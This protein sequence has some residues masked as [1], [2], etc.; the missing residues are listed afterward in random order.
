MN[1]KSRRAKQKKAAAAGAGPQQQAMLKR[2]FEDG[3]KLYLNRKFDD[4]LG[5]FHKIVRA[6]PNIPVVWRHMALAARAMHDYPS[7]ERYINKTIELQPNSAEGYIAL[8]L[9][10]RDQ[11]KYDAAEAA[12]KKAI[13]INPDDAETYVPLSS[14]YRD[15]GEA[16]AARAPLDKALELNPDLVSAHHRRALV[17]DF[18]SKNDDVFKS[19]I[20]MDK[21]GVEQGSRE[22]AF[23]KSAIAKAYEDMGRH[24]DAFAYT[25][26]A[27]DIMRGAFGYDVANDVDYMRR[28]AEFFT[29]E[30][31]AAHAGGGVASDRPVFI[32]GMPRSGT[33]LVE[34][35]L[36]SHPRVYG[37]GELEA[38][39]MA[40]LDE[41]RAD[42]LK[43]IGPGFESYLT[44]K[45][46]KSAARNYLAELSRIDPDSA[47]VTD[48]MPVNFQWL[49]FVR[50]M[51][52][53]A[54][55]V[56]C[57]R[58]PADTCLSIYTKFIGKN[59]P[60][61]FDLEEMGRY[62]VAY[63]KLMD[64]WQKVLG[65][66]I[67]TVQYED[68]VKDQQGITRKMLDFCGL[69]WDDSCLRY[70]EHDRGVRTAS[71]MQVREPIYTDSI[72]RWKRV[73]KQLQ[74]LLNALGDYAKE[75]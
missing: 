41:F 69:D 50:L 72:K 19:L 20:R 65:D 63:R 51:F 3:R 24:K 44:E 39:K 34:Q 25:K 48:K 47:R 75:C 21:E 26:A 16:D 9:F 70:W 2:A 1:R 6:N 67:M 53:N 15:K 14:I 30:R 18:S 56:H 5:V 36:A 32:V 45:H 40:L 68:L 27:N 43:A 4:A 29:D 66:R 60:W 46:I 17:H 64:H 62:Y 8:A 52:P 49:G 73:E 35:I 12:C 38:L 11:G 54:R 31:L 58:N 59:V 42:R 33:T 55:I 7:A 22:A 13:A 23:I 37:A 74:P 10:L 61:Y 57:L 71:V 28:I